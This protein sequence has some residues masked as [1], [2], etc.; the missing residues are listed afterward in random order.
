M[1]LLEIA[2]FVLALP[3]AAFTLVMTYGY[4]VAIKN[5]DIGNGR[6]F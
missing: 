3:S 1:T 6:R 5:G 2:F 4:I